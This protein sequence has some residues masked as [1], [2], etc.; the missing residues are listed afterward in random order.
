MSRAASIETCVMKSIGCSRRRPG[1]RLQQLL[2]A[3]AISGEIVVCEENRAIAERVQ[4]IEFGQHIGDRLMALLA[5]LDRTCSCF[6]V[7]ALAH[8]DGSF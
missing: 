7:L 8:I 4:K 1:H 6:L 2:T 3:G 5:L